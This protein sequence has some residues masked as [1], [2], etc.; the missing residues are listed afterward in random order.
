MDTRDWVASLSALVILQRIAPAVPTPLI[1]VVVAIA[2][3]SIFDLDSRGV[4]VVGDISRQ[5]PLPGI[6]M[7]I[8]FDDIGALFPGALAIALIGYTESNSVAEQFAEEHSYDIK[9]N[10]ELIA[11]GGANVLSGVFQGFVTGGGASQS[12]AND[13]AGAR[14]PLAVLILAALTALTAALLMPVFTNLPQAVLGAIVISAVMGFLNV[15]ALERIRRLRTDS[16]VLSLVSLAGVLILGVLPGL[17]LAVLLS[18]LVLLGY[19]SRPELSR[20]GRLPGTRAFV[21]TE[22]NPEAEVDSR[23]LILRLD[24]PLLYMNASWM[25]DRVRDQIREGDAPTVVVLDLGMSLEL[26]VTGLDKLT[27]LHA[28]LSQTGVE[29]RLANVHAGVAAILERSGLGDK[30]GSERIYRTL[31]D[32]VKVGAG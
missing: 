14:T 30:I 1:V 29:L 3:T 24:A 25:R 26:D 6:P 21:D 16:F 4:A 9:P 2:V 28:D 22:R 11:L 15:P 27:Q 20:L 5:I 32:A 19:Q 17:L 18:V 12:A 10:Q 31:N 7:S 13:R 23:V 8:R